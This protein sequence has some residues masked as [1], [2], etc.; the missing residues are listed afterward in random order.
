MF[1]FLQVLIVILSYALNSVISNEIVTRFV[2]HIS[3][4]LLILNLLLERIE[5]DKETG[6]SSLAAIIVLTVAVL[7]G[8]LAEFY[9]INYSS[10]KL[11]SSVFYASIIYLFSSK[12]LSKLKSTRKWKQLYQKLLIIWYRKKTR[13]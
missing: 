9:K 5:L 4:L 2:L 10:T 8:F 1:V 7:L 3:L 12:I 13:I 11:F 6:L